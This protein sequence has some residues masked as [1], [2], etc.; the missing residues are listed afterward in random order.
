MAYLKEAVENTEEFKSSEH[1]NGRN[2]K[3]HFSLNKTS[4][5]QAYFSGLTW[6]KLL[7]GMQ[8]LKIVTI[9]SKEVNLSVPQV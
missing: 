6:K 1:L 7:R 2:L 8:S 4:L 3:S 9:L 5:L